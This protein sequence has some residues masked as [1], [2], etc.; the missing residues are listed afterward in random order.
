M[1]AN[2]AV[3]H[4]LPRTWRVVYTIGGTTPSFTPTN[5]QAVY[6]L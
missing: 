4:P 6:V 2:A 5:V 1:P 3:S